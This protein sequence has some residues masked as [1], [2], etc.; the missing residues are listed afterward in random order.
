ME[1]NVGKKKKKSNPVSLLVYFA[2][3]QKLIEHCKSTIIKNLGKMLMK[4][5]KKREKKFPPT[6]APGSWH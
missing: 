4:K 6:P 5:E 3:Q 2:V 1:D